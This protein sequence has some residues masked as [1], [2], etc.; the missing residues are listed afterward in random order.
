M[1]GGALGGMLGAALRMFEGNGYSE[2]A[3]TLFGLPIRTPFY[4][5]E[6]ISQIVSLGLFTAVCVYLWMVATGRKAEAGKPE[7]GRA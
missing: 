5:N 6:P 1:A 2:E 3:S 7:G 4:G